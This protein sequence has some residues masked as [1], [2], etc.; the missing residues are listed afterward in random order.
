MSHIL[1][2]HNGLKNTV[3]L[4]IQP[5]SFYSLTGSSAR[6]SPG[7]QIAPHPLV[8]PGMDRASAGLQS[9][10]PPRRCWLRPSIRSSG[11]SAACSS[12]VRCS[13]RTPPGRGKRHRAGGIWGAWGG[14]KGTRLEVHTCGSCHGKAQPLNSGVAGV[15]L[16]GK[17]A[18]VPGLQALT[19][20]AGIKEP[21]S[22]L[23]KGAFLLRAVML[24][25]FVVSDF[26]GISLKVGHL[27]VEDIIFLKGIFSLADFNFSSR[28]HKHK[29]HVQDSCRTCSGMWF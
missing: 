29:D 9:H 23:T 1:S 14:T 6:V 21:V 2:D 24:R 10:K 5:V 3:P 7:R 19:D 26:C 28:R 11:S 22:W 15:G 25:R 13:A 8:P 16:L 27:N 20:G 17:N 4:W 18:A 12:E